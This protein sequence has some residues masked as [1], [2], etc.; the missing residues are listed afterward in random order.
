LHP[1]EGESGGG[2]DVLRLVDPLGAPPA[3][4]AF[5]DAGQNGHVLRRQDAP[6]GFNLQFVLDHAVFSFNAR[7][8][9][10]QNHRHFNEKDG[11]IQDDGLAIAG[12]AGNR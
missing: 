12:P 8:E 4:A 5:A 7:Q 3:S 9:D 10:K 6:F 11:D 2:L 1:T